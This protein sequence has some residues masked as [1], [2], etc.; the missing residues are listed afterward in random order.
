MAKILDGHIVTF[1]FQEV[2]TLGHHS[3]WEIMTDR[4]LELLEDAS[5]YW[6]EDYTFWTEVRV[7]DTGYLVIVHDL[8]ALP[9]PE[10]RLPT[11]GNTALMHRKVVVGQILANLVRQG[12]LQMNS[13]QI[14]ATVEDV[15]PSIP[16]SIFRGADI[17]TCP[18]CVVGEVQLHAEDMTWSCEGCHKIGKWEADR[19][20]E[21]ILHGH[22]HGLDKPQC[23]NC[24]S[25]DLEDNEKPSRRDADDRPEDHR[26]HAR[27]VRTG[28]GHR[29]LRSALHWQTLHLHA[30]G[31]SWRDTLHLAD[32]RLLHLAEAEAS[33]RACDGL[34]LSA[35]RKPGGKAP[36][37]RRAR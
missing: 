15:A 37:H 16:L 23:S 11:D 3:V 21:V 4:A 10:P 29:R 8:P 32:G 25:F 13:E 31:C 6:P 28:K 1:D 12:N 36:D 27:G 33:P 17:L 24:G 2:P 20:G 7:G 34:H 19:Y 22:T 26:L 18:E 14:L 9:P 30:K 35:G 5:P